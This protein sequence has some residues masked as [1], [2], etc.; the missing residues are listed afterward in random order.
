MKGMIYENFG[1]EI[2]VETLPVPVCLPDSVIIEV[3]ATGICR[4]D[5]HGWMGHDGDIVLPH[6]PGHEFSGVIVE[7]GNNISKLQIGDRVVVPFCCGCGTCKVC[8]DGKSHICNNYFQP[9]FT[10]WG[11]FAQYVCI[12]YA[13]YNVVILPSSISFE[14]AASLGCRFI[15]AFRSVINQA[16]I[17]IGQTISIYGCGGVGLS[18]IMIAKAVGAHVIAL[19]VNNTTLQKAKSLGADEIIKIN[20]IEE[21]HQSVLDV[22]PEGTHASIDAFGSMDS[23]IQSILGLSKNGKH[24]QVGLL[25]EGRA[26]PENV[27]SK[28]ISDELEIIGSHG[29]PVGDYPL[30]FDLI[31][32][33]KLDPSRL[34][35]DTIDLSSGAIFLKNMDKH[36]HSGVTLITDLN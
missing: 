12:D 2:N 6:V 23:C 21:A 8:N 15:T 13:E 7:T 27:L 17:Q 24:V 36:V 22:I 25:K 11:S 30:I 29:M 19:D 32:K 16:S 18:A 9:G 5:W 26:L 31:E 33:G 28:L 20:G 35:M 10:S 3:K 4:S 34:I 1:G 14:N